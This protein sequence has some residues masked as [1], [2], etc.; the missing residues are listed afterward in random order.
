MIEE[1]WE[2]IYDLDQMYQIENQLQ[3]EEEYENY[4]Q[5]Q[6]EKLPATIE[7]IFKKSKHDIKRENYKEN[8]ESTSL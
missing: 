1:D 3:I 7:V 2:R 6:E 4:L 5:E 8:Q